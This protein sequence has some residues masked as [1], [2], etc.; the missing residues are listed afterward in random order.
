MSVRTLFLDAVEALFTATAA[1]EEVRVIRSPRAVDELDTRPIAQATTQRY[2]AI[3]EAPLNPRWIGTLTLVSPHRDMEKA[4]DQLETLYEAILP[5]IRSGA[6]IVGQ[7]A[8]AP[9]GQN[10]DG[11]PKLLSLDVDVTSILTSQE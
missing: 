8:L 7:A 10:S 6:F 9:Y 4:E 11:S 3:P 2:E 5:V 1:L